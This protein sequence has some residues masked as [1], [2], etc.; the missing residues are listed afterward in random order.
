MLLKK[1]KILIY[2]L[3]SLFF[4]NL[5]LPFYSFAIDEDSIY[6]WSN[7][8]SS[9]STSTTPTEENQTVTQDNSR[10]LFRYYFWWCYING[11]KNWNYFV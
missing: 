8:S 11:S 7:N 2:M 6:V 10:K 9:V 5:M 3:L 4:L 1:S